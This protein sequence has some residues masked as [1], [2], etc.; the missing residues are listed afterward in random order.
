MHARTRF[1]PQLKYAFCF[2]F[3]LIAISSAQSIA[4][5]IDL[6]TASWIISPN[7]PSPMK[8][9][10]PA[11][12]TEEIAKRT[13]IR[14]KNGNSWPK[15]NVPVIAI[16]LASDKTLFNRNIPAVNS[17]GPETKPE[18]FRIVTEVNNGAKTIWI[19]G[20]DARGI[21]FGT[22]YLLRQ[23]K[24]SQAFMGKPLLELAGPLNVAS[25]PAYAIRGHQ[26]GYRSTANT[27]DAWSV[28]QFDQYIRELAIFG[29]NAVE[30]IPFH[31]DDK[32]S[33]HFKIPAR[34]MRIRM[35]E[36][37]RKYDMDYWVWTPATFELKDP[38]KRQAELDLHEQFYK[39]CPRLN[40]IFFPGGDPGDN[41]PSEVL[42]FLRE[43]QAKLVKYHPKAKMWISLQG[44]DTEQ[45]D[46][47]YKY[48]ETEKPTWLQG[49]VSG[50]GSPPMAETRYRLPKQYQHRQYPDITHQV[51]C[52]FPVE[53]FDQAYALTLGRESVNPR[54]YAFAKIH[55]KYAPFTDGFVSY[56][57]GS[58]DDVNKVLWSMR[59]WDPQMDVHRIM[60][61]Y[62]N[63]FFS[64]SLGAPSIA[65]SAIEGLEQNW[66]GPLAENGAV[67][68]TYLH[69]RVLRRVEEGLENNWRWQ[70][71]VFRAY[72]D[73][74]TRLRLIYE[75]DLEK[76]AN[77]V[78]DAANRGNIIQVMDTALAIVNKANNH[79]VDRDLYK[80]IVDLS[81]ALYK[82]IGLQTSTQKHTPRNP[83]R[84][85]VMDFINY[86]LNN[87]W[88][89]ADE[90]EKIKKM[91][92]PDEQLARL[93]TIAS[94]ENP[95]PGSYYDDVSSVAKGPRVK[96]VSDDAT[97]VAWWDNGM[98][99]KR[100]STQLFQREPALDYDNLDPRAR[101]TIRVAGEGDALLRVD[102]Y[103]LSPV[104][105]SKEP[106]TF[107]EWIVPLSLTQ[108]GKISVTFDGPEESQLNW[109]KQSKISDIWL[110]KQP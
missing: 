64:A 85:V 76:Q 32:P 105:Y 49:V 13:G 77:V 92:S 14:I 45:I 21:L 24:M 27:Y 19:I 95:G 57:D 53:K 15:G 72:Y 89:L 65:A 62:A 79:V 60:E 1:V 81:D 91:T 48:L 26:L 6:K 54:P 29:S 5:H 10:A 11:V 80:E 70:M 69:W 104:I 4:Q 97:D 73:Q 17:S 82:S 42:P 3:L 12:L 47:F 33:P 101:Y 37:C 86:P 110:L 43:L 66:K 2:I 99:R 41:H 108:D 90:F 106:E 34:E 8:E 9:T 61:E 87:R 50:P 96:T 98:S 44:F 46:Y 59:G 55:A 83:E 20:A 22:G 56:S 71:L 40:H 103:R 30:G 58:H 67:E 38:A 100:L 109:R 78:L 94:W 16:A 93:K 35:S 18:G 75:Q 63:F 36:I 23:L 25:S 88:W 31:E 52:E 28:A 74:Y 107:K 39:E 51:R 102:G 68:M 7:V 84:G